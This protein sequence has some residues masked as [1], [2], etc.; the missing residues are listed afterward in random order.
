MGNQRRWNH[1]HEFQ[2]KKPTK[3]KKGHPAYVFA[4]SGDNRKHF[5]FTHSP[6]TDG[7]D[8]IKLKHNIDPCECGRDTYMRPR[9]YISK[10]DS[11]EPSKKPYR[12]HD[13]DLHIIKK[14]KNK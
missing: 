11:F 13:D 1:T 8:N 9:A 5:V 6:T 14:Y 2:W 3:S 12:I 10:K 4:K 7:E